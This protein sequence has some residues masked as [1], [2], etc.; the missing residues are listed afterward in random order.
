VSDRSSVDPDPVLVR[1]LQELL[2]CEV[3]PIIC[4]DS[5]GHTKLVDDV[6]EKLDSFLGAGLDDQFRLNPLG[7]LVHRDEQAGEAARGLLERPDHV[8]TPDRER[9]GEGDGL[10]R[11]CWQVGLPSVELA[12]LACTDN[13]LCVAQRRWPVETLAKGLAD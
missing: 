8:E 3:S 7:E 6:K 10:K 5:I 11:M 13:F 12:P 2:A 9:P 1:E 4:A